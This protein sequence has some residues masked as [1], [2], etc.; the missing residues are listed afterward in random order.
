MFPWQQKHHVLF[1]QVCIWAV[2]RTVPETR[3]LKRYE[4]RRVDPPFDKAK[5]HTGDLAEEPEPSLVFIKL[6]KL[7]SPAFSICS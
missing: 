2:Y 3:F 6:L 5:E 1:N 7:Q 4:F